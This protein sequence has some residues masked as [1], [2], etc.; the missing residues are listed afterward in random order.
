M[1]IRD[2]AGAEGWE[3][4]E[5]YGLA[6]QKWLAEFLELPS[7]IPSDDT[8]R[9]VFERIDPQVLEQCL[10]L[11]IRGIV[12]SLEGKIVPLDGKTIKGSYDRERGFKALHLVTA[13]A[14]E[15]RLILGQIKVEDSSNEITAIPALLELLDIK[16]AI[17]TIDGGLKLTSLS[18]IHI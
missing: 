2:S 15:Q 6:K 9:R 18:L 14:S 11:W 4:I 8:F 1:C 3:D 16:G 17:V 7:G 13:W 5:N 10:S 12:S